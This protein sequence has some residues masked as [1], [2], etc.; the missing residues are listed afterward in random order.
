VK[1]FAV[2]ENPPMTDLPMSGKKSTS[3]YDF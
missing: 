1:L 3:V 2:S